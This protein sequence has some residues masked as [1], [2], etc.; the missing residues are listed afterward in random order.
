MAEDTIRVFYLNWT[1][2]GTVEGSGDA[3]QLK[4]QQG[5]Y[6]IS[7]AVDT[8]GTIAIEILLNVYGAG[9]SVPIYWKTAATQS[10]LSGASWNLYIAEFTSI[11]FV[12][13]KL[14]P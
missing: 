2:T 11:G 3:E 8:E 9:D 5:Q 6:M 1:G 4:I 10:G 7:E 12:Q 14:E 13:L